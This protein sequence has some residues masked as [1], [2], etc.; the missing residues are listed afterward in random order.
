MARDGDRL[1][2]HNTDGAGFVSSLRI[3][4]G[5]DP[6]GRRCVVLGAGGAARAVV[7]ALAEAGAAEVVV[8]N[9]SPDRAADAAELA[10]A[11]GRIAETSALAAPLADADLLVN[12]TPVG[13]DAI[14][15]PV[16]AALLDVLPDGALVADLVYQPLV[17]PLLGLAAGRGLATLDGLGMLVYQAAEAFERWT[18]TAAPVV[19]MR[20]AGEASG[21]PGE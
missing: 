8:V 20:R 14:S 12:A 3:G 5:F 17:T 4:A 11:I 21:V 13:M 2:G 6:A 9:R 16:D 10:G 18:A 1:I 19:E 15:T 7:L